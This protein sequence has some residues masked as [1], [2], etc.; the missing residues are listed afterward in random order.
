MADSTLDPQISPSR[1]AAR[2][3]VRHLADYNCP[4]STAIAKAL[5]VKRCKMGDT[6]IV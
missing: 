5:K 2:V 3:K 6:S 1:L 4:V